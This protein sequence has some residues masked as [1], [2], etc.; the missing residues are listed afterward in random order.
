MG[1]RGISY[2]YADYHSRERKGRVIGSL[3]IDCIR[4]YKIE[5]KNLI[6][7]RFVD[8]YSL[9]SFMNAID[10]GCIPVYLDRWLILREP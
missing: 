1:A 6:F 10:S 5:E 3:I 7:G 9:T 8:H 4:L 2:Y